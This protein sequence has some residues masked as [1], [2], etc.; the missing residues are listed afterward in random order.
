MAC[1]VTP[2][3]RHEAMENRLPGFSSARDHESNKQLKA[4]E[5]LANEPR[6]LLA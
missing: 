6:G 1:R 2:D 3:R 4:M 5:C